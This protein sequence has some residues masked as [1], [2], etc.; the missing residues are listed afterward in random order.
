MYKQIIADIA[1]DQPVL[2][3]GPT[4]S[5]KSALALAIAE[6]QGGVIVNADASQIFECWRIITARPDEEEEKRAPHQLF[7]HV[8][9]DENYSAGHWARDLKKV[10]AM[11]QRPI[12]VGGTGL[13]FSAAIEGFANIPETPAN[14]RK[15][16][17]LMSLDELRAQL[18]AE[19]RDK[20]DVANRARVQRAWEIQTAT[21]L[22]LAHWHRQK[23]TPLLV[24]EHV[25]KFVFEAPKDWLNPRIET[26][27]EQMI[28]MGALE[29]VS[30]MA[31]K[32]KPDLPS[33]KAIGVPELLAVHAGNLS[34]EDAK[35]RIII[36]TRQYAKRQRTWF[37]KRCI[38]W[39]WLCVG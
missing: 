9:Y 35:A 12:L 16:G 34:L 38:D 11:G 1:E 20:I 24:A 3:A 37:R 22:S 29:E 39:H 13:Y 2:I 15:T 27:L 6:A 31:G 33:F 19:T 30:A 4:A 25:K 7:G 23:T 10:L 28:T 32:H 21:G 17:D 26:R 5:G 14:V 18:D 36:A 8:A